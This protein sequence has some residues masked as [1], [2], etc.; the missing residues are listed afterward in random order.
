MQNPQ[1]G[2][3]GGTEVIALLVDIENAVREA[4]DTGTVGTV[5]ETEGVSNLVNGLLH[6]SFEE[7]PP[8]ACEPVE[9]GIEP[10]G[11]NYGP[12]SRTLSL[13]KDEVQ[14]ARGSEEVFLGHGQKPS[15]NP[16]EEPVHDDVRI[17]LPSGRMIGCGR[18][19]QERSNQTV[20]LQ[21]GREGGRKFFQHFPIHLPQPDQSQNHSFFFRKV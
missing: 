17:E 15:R 8:V 14:V 4:H 21:A 7:K 11:G 1:L 13:P 20:E 18:K 3:A 9:R 10:A 5:G 16:R 2:G 12:S 19:V 6:Q